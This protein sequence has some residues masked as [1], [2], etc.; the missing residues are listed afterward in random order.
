MLSSYLDAKDRGINY[1]IREK[2][3]NEVKSMNIEKLLEFHKKYIKNKPHNVLLIG[4]R[5]NIDFKNLEKY[6]SV[7]EISLETLF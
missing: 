3:Y 5:D 1:D 6:G 2:I 4:N 7:K